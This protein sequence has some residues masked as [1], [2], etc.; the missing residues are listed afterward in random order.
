MSTH[1]YS[2]SIQ[3]PRDHLAVVAAFGAPVAPVAP[4]AA[5]A[6]AGAAAAGAGAAPL[7]APPP[8]VAGAACHYACNSIFFAAVG[9]AYTAEG[10][11]AL[12]ECAGH[13]L[14][15]ATP[16]ASGA[17]PLTQVPILLHASRLSTETEMINE[18]AS[19]ALRF[20]DHTL[21]PVSK[22]RDSVTVHLEST[23]EAFIQ[24]AVVILAS[25]SHAVMGLAPAVRAQLPAIRVEHVTNG[26]GENQALGVVTVPFMAG[27]A[28]AL[29]AASTALGLACFGGH[30]A[31][32]APQWK[33]STIPSYTLAPDGSRVPVGFYWNTIANTLAADEGCRVGPLLRAVPA[34]PDTSLSVFSNRH[35]L[36]A[37]GPTASIIAFAPRLGLLRASRYNATAVPL[38]H[39]T[40]REWGDAL[41]KCAEY[42]RKE[43]KAYT[44]PSTDGGPNPKRP[45]Q[46]ATCPTCEKRHIGPCWYEKDKSAGGK[47]HQDGGGQPPPLYFLTLKIF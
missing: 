15:S 37:H 42:N 31:A 7:E 22:V 36:S 40:W 25:M 44:R 5:A 38:L 30:S 34:N 26:A 19:P 45:R 20:G 14:T 23:T 1:K 17:I 16:G 29:A 4:I 47:P 24:K 41:T 13:I 11:P 27:L 3:L 33:D 10:Q 39:A 18:K 28:S 32:E 46:T 43:A 35:A 6:V 9:R 21:R 2:L 12:P 8:M